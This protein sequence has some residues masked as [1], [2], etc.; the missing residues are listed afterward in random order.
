MYLILPMCYLVEIFNQLFHFHKCIL[1]YLCFILFFS[2]YSEYQINSTK[3]IFMTLSYISCWYW[4]HSNLKT[5]IFNFQFLII[6]LIQIHLN[7][8]KTNFNFIW[9]SRILIFNSKL[10]YEVAGDLENIKLNLYFWQIIY[11]LWY[12]NFQYFININNFYLNSAIGFHQNYF[13]QF[14][15]HYNLCYSRLF[16]ID[17]FLNYC[18]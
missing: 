2:N 4:F 11:L 1:N 3:S 8:L 5:L 17:W 7:C 14:S 10:I 12:Q 15:I 16:V 13:D 18:E 9:F 6:F